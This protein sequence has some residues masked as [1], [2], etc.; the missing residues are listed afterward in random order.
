VKIYFPWKLQRAFEEAVT[1]G[2][3]VHGQEVTSR[4][5]AQRYQTSENEARLVLQAAYRKG[6]VAQQ[7][8]EAFEVLGLPESRFPSVHTHTSK[9]GLNPRSQVRA[10]EIEPAE[11]EVAAQL[12][13]PEGAPV[14]RFER[15][16]H[17]NE[18][19]LANQTNYMPVEVCFG[20]E[21][22]DVSRFSFQKLLEQKYSVVLTQIKEHFELVP[23]TEQD[24]EILDLPASSS[25]LLVQRLALS[26][27][28]RPVVWANIRIRPDRYAY[29]EAL[30]PSAAQLLKE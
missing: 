18:Q 15:T 21:T 20:L 1:G 27:T 11:T 10:V 24:Q 2:V 16:R 14:Y 26:A 25:I 30:W 5:V 9:S 7:G 29:V 4:Q 28:E 12:E 13:L 22:D 17:V 6:L 23:S 19:A 8:A 3:Y